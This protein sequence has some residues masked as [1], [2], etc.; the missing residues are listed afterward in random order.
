MSNEN[1][2]NA[3]T[4]DFCCLMEDVMGAFRK[5]GINEAKITLDLNNDAYAKFLE[6]YLH[7]TKKELN[8]EFDFGRFNYKVNEIKVQ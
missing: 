8:N 3:T 7:L 6:G 2:K 4:F 1:I 5:Y